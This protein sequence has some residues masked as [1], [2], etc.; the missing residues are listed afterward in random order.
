MTAG[1]TPA[2]RDFFCL[3]IVKFGFKG[4]KKRIPGTNAVFGGVP[5]GKP[6]S[7]GIRVLFGYT[8]GFV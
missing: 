3:N 2:L 6:G 1:Q 8:G 5:A 7:S 4:K